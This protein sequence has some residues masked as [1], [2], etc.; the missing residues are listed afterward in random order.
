MIKDL[1]DH[2]KNMLDKADEARAEWPLLKMG[3]MEIFSKELNSLSWEQVNR[4]FE[5]EY[6]NILN[7]FDLVLTLPATSTACEGGFSH[8]KLVKSIKRTLISEATLSNSLM[9]KLECCGVEEFNPDDAI[10]VK[11]NKCIRRP[12]TSKTT[13]N[14]VDYI[15]PQ[16]QGEGT[17]Q[18]DDREM[19]ETRG[20]E[21]NNIA[22]DVHDDHVAGG[23]NVIEGYQLVD[24]AEDDSDYE[25]DYDS[26]GEL[27]EHI[28]NKIE[29]Y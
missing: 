17:Q 2:Y 10:E 19:E 26:D 9:I 16:V 20:N 14:Y 6:P 1:I 13:D 28:F 4:R 29:N 27:A 7:V 8:I 12:G 24:D 21:E 3:I 25:L 5:K 22:I 18:K 23:N 15:E 11:F